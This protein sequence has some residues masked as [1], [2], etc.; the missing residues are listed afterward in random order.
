MFVYGRI[1]LSDVGCKELIVC[2]LDRSPWGRFE[3]G[4][5]CVEC[6]KL[7]SISRTKT[8]V[9][10]KQLVNYEWGGRTEGSADLVPFLKGD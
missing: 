5:C 2:L 9:G 8:S 10:W 4:L 3:E 6:G 7:F 1:K